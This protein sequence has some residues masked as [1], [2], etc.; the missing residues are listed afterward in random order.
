MAMFK[1]IGIFFQ[2]YGFIE[3]KGC[4]LL[5]KLLTFSISGYIGS[6]IDIEE[7][8]RNIVFFFY[9]LAYFPLTQGTTSAQYFSVKI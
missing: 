4:S 9:F 8:Y 2:I 5:I 1:H 7:G 3:F 6:C